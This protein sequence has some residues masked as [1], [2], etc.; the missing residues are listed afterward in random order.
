MDGRDAHG[1]FAAGNALGPGRP[2]RLTEKSYL[3]VMMQNCSLQDWAEIVTRAVVA[4]KTGDSSARQWLG[5]FLCGCPDKSAPTPLDLEIEAAAG[6][7]DRDFDQAVL[8]HRVRS[9]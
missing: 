5:R 4:A 3:R 1:K 9:A 6:T 7:E 8:F 2:R